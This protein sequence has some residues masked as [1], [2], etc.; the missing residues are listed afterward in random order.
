MADALLKLPDR[1]SWNTWIEATI[2]LSLRIAPRSNNT[3]VCVKAWKV[4]IRPVKVRK[5]MTGESKG[6]VI[7]KKV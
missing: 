1:N 3:K 6:S 5:K 7:L 2:K 4:P